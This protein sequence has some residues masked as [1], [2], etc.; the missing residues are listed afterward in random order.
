MEVGADQSGWSGAQ[1][2]GWCVYLCYP[3]LHHEVQTKISSGTGLP[4]SPG[5]RAVKRF[6][7]CVCVCQDPY[8]ID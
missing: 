4:G 7:V 6:C 2:D 8:I 5:K 3:R 1:A